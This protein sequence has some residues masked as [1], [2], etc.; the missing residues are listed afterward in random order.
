[1]GS[2]VDVSIATELA[3]LSVKL[4][5]LVEQLK[6]SNTRND[7]ILEDH[8]C[9]IRWLERRMWGVPVSLVSC[10]VTAFVALKG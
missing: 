5:G 8:E 10:I 7:K 9:R 6:E 2:P 3:K 1:M 4:D